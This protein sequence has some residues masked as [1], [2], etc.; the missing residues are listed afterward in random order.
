[1]KIHGL[2]IGMLVLSSLFILKGL[3]LCGLIQDIPL[4]ETLSLLVH[5]LASD[6]ASDNSPP[7]LLILRAYLLSWFKFGMTLALFAL[8]AQK[9]KGH[10]L[11]SLLDEFLLYLHLGYLFCYDFI[12]GGWDSIMEGAR[13]I[14]PPTMVAL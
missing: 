14:Q 3:E 1:M 13:L 6:E 8:L 7:L 4:T 5:H 10:L 2:N 9:L 12:I 11:L